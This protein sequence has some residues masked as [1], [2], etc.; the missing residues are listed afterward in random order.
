MARSADF[1]AKVWFKHSQVADLWSLFTIYTK[2]KLH[3]VCSSGSFVVSTTSKGTCV[4][5]Y[6]MRVT[7]ERNAIDQATTDVYILA[8]SHML[9]KGSHHVAKIFR[10]VL[11]S[12]ALC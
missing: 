9:S 8:R 6:H 7:V 1:V 2:C 3:C 4:H 11:I 10:R 12:R 5:V